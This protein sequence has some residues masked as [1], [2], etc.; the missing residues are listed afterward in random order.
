MSGYQIFTQPSQQALDTAANVLSG[1]TLT[2]QVTGTSTPTDAYS[3]PTLTTP[4]ANPLSANGAGVFV[5]VFLDPEVVYRIILKTQAG[6]TLQTWDPANENIIALFTQQY[7]GQILF[8]RTSLEI[9][10]GVTPVSYAYEAPNIL[11]YGADS[12]GVADSANAIRQA[13]LANSYAYIPGGFTFKVASTIVIT[14]NIVTIVGDRGGSFSGQSSG[15]NFTGT[16]SLFSATG[17]E[18][19][20]IYI[21]H[22]SIV[23]GS[24]DGAYCIHST[25]PQSLFEYIHMEDAVVGY[26]NPGIKLSSSSQGSWSSCIRRC[27]WVGPPSTNAFRG[28]YVD[29]DGGNVDLEWCT[30]TRG[31]VGCEIIKGET[32]RLHK[33][34]F[35]LQDSASSSES[36]TA[37]QNSV[38]LSGVASKKSVRLDTCYL[39][40]STTCLWVESVDSLK[41]VSTFID[42]LGAGTC[43][44]RIDSSAS[45]NVTIDSCNMRA[46]LNGGKNILNAGTGTIITGTTLLT[47]GDATCI[48]LDN[49]G[50]GLVTINNRITGNVAGSAIQTTQPMVDIGNTLVSGGRL[51]TTGVTQFLFPSTGTWTPALSGS[52]TAGANTYATQQ[53]TYFTIGRRVFAD[54]VITLTAKDGAMAGNIRISGLPFTSRNLAVSASAVLIASYDNI[55]LSAGKSQLTAVVSANSTLCALIECGDNVASASIAAAGITN[56]TSLRGTAIY[57]F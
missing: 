27:K 56:T 13:L 34:N 53:G 4:L 28:Y 5:P 38:R 36:T 39:E 42:D 25:R 32:I 7:I 17:T 9:S 45:K 2:F 15:I 11:R 29:I 49:S 3:E 50:E 47:D 33:C 19:G 43:N 54:F 51:D 44:V 46:R 41:V 1:A 31:S 30:G 37:G 21:G 52:G 12:T 8:P 26:N 55:D 14:G 35:N 18:F 20:N 48:P 10:N 24:G 40:G 22:L 23:G 57:D 16:G 6:V